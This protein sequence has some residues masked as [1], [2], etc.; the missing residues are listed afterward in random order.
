MGQ[1]RKADGGSDV[2]NKGRFGD[3]K[4]VENQ[5]HTLIP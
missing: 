2:P 5:K 3:T 1:I 4:K